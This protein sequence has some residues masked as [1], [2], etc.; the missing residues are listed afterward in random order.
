MAVLVWFSWDWKGQVGEEEYFECMVPKYLRAEM[1]S[2]TYSD[3]GFHKIGTL[4]R[5]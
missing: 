1:F 4:S 3:L 2:V 5:F